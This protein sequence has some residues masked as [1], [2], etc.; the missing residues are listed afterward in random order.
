[1]NR[2]SSADEY[3]AGRCDDCGRRSYVLHTHSWSRDLG[4]IVARGEKVCPACK[5]K[6]GGKT[7]R[8]IDSEYSAHPEPSA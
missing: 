6:R 8:E 3:G 7:L 4:E 1:M 5:R 2:E